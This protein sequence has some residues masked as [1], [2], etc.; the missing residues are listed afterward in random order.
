MSKQ[1]LSSQTLLLLTVFT[2][3]EVTSKSNY[4]H[5]Q[6][7]FPEQGPPGSRSGWRSLW[8]PSLTSSKTPPGSMM[9]L[10]SLVWSSRCPGEPIVCVYWHLVTWATPRGDHPA[11]ALTVDS[12]VLSPGTSNLISMRKRRVD[13]WVSCNMWRLWRDYAFT[14]GPGLMRMVQT[15]HTFPNIRPAQA[16]RMRTTYFKG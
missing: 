15:L 8:A 2:T 14:S 6:S 4:E 7:Y 3:L 10:S 1:Q 11:N 13:R 9:T 12:R 16:A 5:E